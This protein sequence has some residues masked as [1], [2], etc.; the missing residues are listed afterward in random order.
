[1][2]QNLDPSA[3]EFL[4]NLTRVQSGIRRATDQ[5]SSG[6]KVN[7][8]SDAPDQISEILQLYVDMG[9]NAQLQSNLSRMKSEVGTAEAALETAI[10]AVDRARTLGSL[11][12]G[13]I[14]TAETRIVLAGEVQ[15]LLEQLVSASRTVGV[16]RYIFS[17]DLDQTP[18]YELNLLEPNGVNRLL[19]APSTRLI[20]HPSGV[21]FKAQKTAQEIFDAR[22]ADDTLATDNVFAAVNGLRTALENNDQDGIDTSLT[23]LRAAGDHLNVELGFYGAAQNNIDEDIDFLYKLDVRL[24]TEMSNRRDAD[25]TAAILELERGKVH[26]QA[27]LTARA[28]LPRT[29]LF[30]FLR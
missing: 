18:A 8:P 15:S 30:D 9:W 1:M 13:T 27:A 17:G 5:I 16:G 25:L 4:V 28:Q 6:L 24:K 11:G 22:N 20:Q 21:S 19:T 29:S 7:T 26:E 12:A 10:R 23:A 14:Q 2:I 3:Q